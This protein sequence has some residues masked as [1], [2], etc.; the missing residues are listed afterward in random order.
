MKALTFKVEEVG[1]N[2]FISW[3]LED[4]PEAVRVEVHPQATLKGE[5]LDALAE[6]LVSA[7]SAMEQ[8]SVKARAEALQRAGFRQR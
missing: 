3:N 2:H 5:A 6:A 1:F 8:P 4:E 7:R